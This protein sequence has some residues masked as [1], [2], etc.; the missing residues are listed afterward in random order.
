[1]NQR[2]VA[3]FSTLKERLRCG[4]QDVAEDGLGVEVRKEAAAVG[5]ERLAG[6]RI[7]LHGRDGAKASGLAS[8]V[9]PAGSG[10]KTD[11]AHR[12]SNASG[13]VG[14][15]RV[16]GHREPDRPEQSHHP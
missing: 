7:R 15:L 3:A 8:K 6:R 12:A 1:M 11:G 10:E 2:D 4:R 14:H 16:A 9:Q 13:A 5:D